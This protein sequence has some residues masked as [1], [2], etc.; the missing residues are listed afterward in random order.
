MEKDRSKVSIIIPNY[1]GKEHLKRLLPS[2]A[3][4][5]F[6]DYEII[7]IDDF[8][9]DR[10]V[11]EYIGEFIKAHKN[12]RLIENTENLGFVKTCN[13]GFRLANGDYICLLTND[14]EVENDFVERN[15]EIMDNDTYIGVL[16]CIIVDYRGNNWFSGGGFKSGLISNLQDDFQSLRSV[17]WVAGTACF[18]RREVFTEAGFLNED[19]FMYHEDVDF[20]LRV[21][22]ETDYKVCMFPEKL[23]RHYM[24]D[25]GPNLDE[26]AKRYRIVYYV[27]RNHIL[28]LRKHCPRYIPKILLYNLWE[29]IRLPIGFIL[30]LRFKSFLLSYPFNAIVIW[31]ILVGLLKRQSE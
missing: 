28:L 2:I 18:Y 5:T 7:I 29:I 16:S 13:K 9:P 8:S 31:G 26:L 12:M 21:R 4:Q 10:S 3:N 25:M 27:H 11:L 20:C 1:N 6:D 15:V 22:N 19:F 23:V 24:P 17:D 30:K 14:T